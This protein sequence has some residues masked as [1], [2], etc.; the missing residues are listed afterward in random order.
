MESRV[1]EFVHKMN[2]VLFQVVFC[3]MADLQWPL[4]KI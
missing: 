3:T 2:K 4:I 1:L